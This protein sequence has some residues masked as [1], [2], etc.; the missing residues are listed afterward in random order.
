MVENITKPHEGTGPLGSESLAHPQTAF[1]DLFT[2]S[3]PH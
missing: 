2:H 1:N 3:A